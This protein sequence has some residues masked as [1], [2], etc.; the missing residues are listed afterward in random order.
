[1]TIVRTLLFFI[2]ISLLDSFISSLSIS[3][4]NLAHIYQRSSKSQEDVLR[5]ERKNPFSPNYQDWCYE[6]GSKSNEP[7]CPG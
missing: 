6:D 3:P 5:N 7:M 1:M 2:F 4:T